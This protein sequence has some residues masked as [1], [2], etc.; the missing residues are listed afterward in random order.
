MVTIKNGK[1]DLELKF[2]LGE[3]N[4]IDRALGYE[5][6]EIN[7][8]EGLETLLP[9]LQSGNVLAIAKIIKACTRG[10]KGHPRKE[11][12]EHILTGVVET[13]GSFKA[14]GKVLIEEL[15]NKP[16]TQDLVKMK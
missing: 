3:L 13:Y 12:L 8:G 11:E 5:V 16:L 6:R 2:G 1:Y 15:G 14:F 4:A 10:Q 7:L 9:K